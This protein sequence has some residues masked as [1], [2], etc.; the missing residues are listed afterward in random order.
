MT[1]VTVASGAV[2]FRAKSCISSFHFR[3]W[4]R[5]AKKQKKNRVRVQNNHVRHKH[6]LL[7]PP[8]TVMTSD[9]KSNGLHSG[10]G[11]TRC[12]RGRIQRQI[13]QVSQSQHLESQPKSNENNSTESNLWLWA[14]LGYTQSGRY[15]QVLETLFT[16][17]LRTITSDSFLHIKPSH[18]P[19]PVA[20]SG[21]DGPVFAA[22]LTL[23]L[24]SFWAQKPPHAW[25]ELSS[26]FRC[27]RWPAEGSRKKLA[28]IWKPKSDLQYARLKCVGGK[29]R[30][31]TVPELHNQRF[32]ENSLT[33]TVCDAEHW[34]EMWREKW[35]I[36]RNDH[37]YRNT[38]AGFRSTRLT[39]S[40]L[41]HTRHQ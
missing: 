39:F 34:T 8:I 14:R 35:L 38:S 15:A 6:G 37:A 31:Q 16:S 19:S 30:S 10:H 26:S 1:G 18:T 3:W 20:G 23:P 13:G 7:A 33:L 32:S 41:T 11:N 2:P 5:C 36:I 40:I 27:L 4:H 28:I 9:S 29:R 21:R 25:A 24:W 12:S 17:N 22:T